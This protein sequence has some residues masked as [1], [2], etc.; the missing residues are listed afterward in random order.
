[1]G[2]ANLETLWRS[3]VRKPVVMKLYLAMRPKLLA[4]KIKTSGL[5]GNFLE[6]KKLTCCIFLQ[7]R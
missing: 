3:Q 4:Y 1:M 6:E 7:A 2:Q 5:R